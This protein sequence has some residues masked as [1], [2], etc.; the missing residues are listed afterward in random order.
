MNPFW[1]GI[2]S[3]ILA[4]LRSCSSCGGWFRV[5]AE[6]RSSPAICSYCGKTVGPPLV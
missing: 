4:S 3:A 1:C 5:S 2:I 6:E